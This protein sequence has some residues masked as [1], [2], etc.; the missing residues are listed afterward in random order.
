VDEDDIWSDEEKM[1]TKRNV[2]QFGQEKEKRFEMRNG[3]SERLKGNYMGVVSEKVKA[4]P[5]TPLRS[6]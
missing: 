4:V 6:F 1:R 5:G 2:K 3:S